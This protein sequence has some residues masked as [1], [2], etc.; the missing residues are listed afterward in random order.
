MTG[1]LTITNCTGGVV[2][3]NVCSEIVV[4]N[5]DVALENNLEI[6]KTHKYKTIGDRAYALVVTTDGDMLWRTRSFTQSSTVDAPFADHSTLE[7]FIEW[8]NNSGKL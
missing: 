8:V 6:A 1:K 3:N 7:D 5:S 4:E 2:S